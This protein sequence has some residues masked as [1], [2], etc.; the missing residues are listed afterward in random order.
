ME[1]IVKLFL[2]SMEASNEQFFYLDELVGKKKRKYIKLS[3]ILNATDIVPNANQWVPSIVK[4]LKEMGYDL[5]IIDLN[6][7][8]G[9]LGDVSK[10]FSDSDVIWICGG[11]TYYLRWLLK[12]TGV[13]KLIIE[14]V[15]KGKVYAGWSAGAIV[16]GPTTLFFDIMGDNPEDVIERIDYGLGL[17]NYVIVPHMNNLE[18]EKSARQV[19]DRLI[20]KGFETIELDDNQVAIIEGTEVKII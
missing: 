19:N 16:A 8:E 11:H 7:T 2:Y 15:N 13:D 20:K 1:K 17:T 10:K 12:K 5:N 14:Q 9:N 4:A 3:V 18:F 6:K